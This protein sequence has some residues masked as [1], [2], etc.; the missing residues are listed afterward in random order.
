M[1]SNAGK[2][3][4]KG[5]VVVSVAAVRKSHAID[6]SDSHSAQ[7]NSRRSSGFRS[8]AYLAFD[9]LTHLHRP[10]PSLQLNNSANRVLVADIPDPDADDLYLS[11]TISN[12]RSGP[13]IPN[14]EDCFIPFK[15]KGGGAIPSVA[16][17]E[18]F[19]Y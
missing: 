2:F 16:S 8:R 14:T 5:D 15:D 4:A 7:G 18:F 13:L 3:T 10:R 9:R 17:L 6:S 12:P 11:V 1:R 19:C